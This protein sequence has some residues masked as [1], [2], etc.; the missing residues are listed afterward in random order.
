MNFYTKTAIFTL[1]LVILLTGCEDGAVHRSYLAKSTSQERTIVG[2]MRAACYSSQKTVRRA[3]ATRASKPS[4]NEKPFIDEP[5]MNAI[6][7]WDANYGCYENSKTSSFLKDVTY[8]KVYEKAYG[9]PLYANGPQIT[10]TEP[11]L[12]K[13]T[14]TETSVVVNK[15]EYISPELIDK[16]TE[17]VSTCFNAKVKTLELMDQ[18]DGLLT[19]DNYEEVMKLVMKCKTSKL[20]QEV[21]RVQ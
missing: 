18:N 1:P 9:V 12:Q 13:P 20:R 14:T 7:F 10:I 11:M 21:E 19:S 8:N 2:Y 5:V 17:S 16:L 15:V 4:E 6:K 3:I